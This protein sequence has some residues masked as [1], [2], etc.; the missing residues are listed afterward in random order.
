[1]SRNRLEIEKKKGRKKNEE[2]ERGGERRIR[3]RW[4]C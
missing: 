4:S 1:L 2:G 3:S